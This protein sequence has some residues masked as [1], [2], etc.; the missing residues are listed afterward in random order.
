MK[1]SPDVSLRELEWIIPQKRAPLSRLGL[2]SLAD[3][4]RHYPRRYE[5][6]RDFDR[7]PESEM[8]RPVCIRGTITKTSFKRLGGWRRAFEATLENPSAGLMSSPITLRWFNMPYMQKLIMTGLDLVIYGRPKMKGRQILI[9]HPE[10][11]VLEADDETSIHMR[12]IVPVH[13]AGDGITPRQ[14]REII[15]RALE[16]TDLERVPSLLPGTDRGHLQAESLRAIHFPGT[17]EAIEGARSDLALEEFFSMQ[18]LIQSRRQRWRH[19]DGMAKE[20]KGEL[21]ETLLSSLPFSPTNSQMK[22]ID[23][24]RDD[25]ASPRRMNR[26]LQGDVGSGKT[27]VA[28]AAMVHAVDSGFGAAIMAPTQILAE[29]HYLNFQRLL[30]PL[31]IPLVLRTG[32]KKTQEAPLFSQ[33]PPIYVGTHALL[34]DEST[35][36]QPGLVVIDE[37]HKFGVMQRAK[38]MERTGAP[39]VLVMTA[40]PIPRTLTQTLYGD[41]EVSI[42]S[43][44]PANRGEVRTVVRASTKLPEVAAYIRTRIEK[45]RQAY[46]VYSL[47][48]ES[49][50]LEA[51]A[52]ADEFEKWKTLLAPHEIGLL[53]GRMNTDDKADAMEAFRS[54]RTAVLV[55]TTVIEVGVDVPN[56]T[57]LLVE[58][59]ERFGLAQLHQLRG[60]IGRSEWKGT[61]VLL[62]DPKAPTEAVE[63]LTVLEE[64]NDGFAVAEADLRLRGPGNLLGTAQTGLPPLRLGDLLADAPLMSE[65][66]ELA[67]DLLERDPDLAEA[68]HIHL[69]QFVQ[70]SEAALEAS[71]G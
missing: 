3:L 63:K 47:I 33:L 49:E 64:T 7:F 28:L 4:L 68:D 21:V 54:G 56:A 70:Q 69:R 23:E 18:L 29:Q 14:M 67:K 38:L 37:Q 20:P 50:K 55:S 26:L 44:R 6:R 58:N 35:E 39:D 66:S 5:D 16:E 40:T 2:H 52:A 1:L 27:L 32:S 15:H 48:D 25:L 8:S 36:F 43:E 10:Y 41:L 30:A 51:K 12:R 45:G 31:G 65:A 53:H 61:C 17:P 11:E 59:A 62:H 24:I 57:V 60:R 34:F 46:I 19:A 71:A 9:D 13:P 42:L 22:V